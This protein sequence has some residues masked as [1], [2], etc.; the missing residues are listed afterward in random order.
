MRWMAILAAL[1]FASAFSPATQAARIG[2]IARQTRVLTGTVVGFDGKRLAISFTTPKG[3]TRE[4]KIRGNKE[5]KV[6][7]DGTPVEFSSLRA[8]EKVTVTLSHGV[9]TEVIASS[10]PATP[11]SEP[12]SAN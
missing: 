1:I 7:L 2:K 5:T 10:A 12:S 6:T 3:Q 11:A 4:R 8:G 9:A